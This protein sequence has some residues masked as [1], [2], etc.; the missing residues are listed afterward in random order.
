MELSILQLVLSPIFSMVLGFIWYS[1]PV[2]GKMWMKEEGLT[3]NDLKSGP[4]VGYALTFVAAAALGVT[5]AVLSQ[6]V[7]ATTFMDGLSFGL[8]VGFGIVATT[9]IPASIFGQESFK[10][11]AINIGYQ[12]VNVAV[13]SVLVTVL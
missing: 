6:K 8:L 2:F 5:L 12:L 9:M 3:E 4:G 10:L 11:M 7:G 13:I 1:L